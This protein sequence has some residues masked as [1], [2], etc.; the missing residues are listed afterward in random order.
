M[1]IINEALKKAQEDNR[2]QADAAGQEAAQQASAPSDAKA[3]SS[4]SARRHNLKLSTEIK[5]VVPALIIL[6]VIAAVLFYSKGFFRSVSPAA[7][8]LLAPVHMVKTAFPPATASPAQEETQQA[9]A[10]TPVF[11]DTLDFPI[12]RLSG[13]VYD[14]ERPYAIVNNRVVSKGDTIDGATLI[15]V[16]QESVMFVFNDKEFE[17]RSR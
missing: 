9:A 13:I 16:R 15:E 2:Q 6:I 14:N 7:N 3:Y 5:R 1:S 17:V 12:L 8:L 4:P 10:V 11:Q